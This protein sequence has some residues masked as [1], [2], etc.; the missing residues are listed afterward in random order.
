[1]LALQG[2]VSGSFAW[3]KRDNQGE[4]PC[5]VLNPQS[6]KGWLARL[7]RG[8]EGRLFLGLLYLP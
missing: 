1:M 2:Y 7:N 8:F 3:C 5:A 4:L 6:V